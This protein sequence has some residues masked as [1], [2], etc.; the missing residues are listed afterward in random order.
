MRNRFNEDDEHDYSPNE[1]AELSIRHKDKYEQ[2][3]SSNLKE[4]DTIN[5]REQR[6]L[7]RAKDYLNQQRRNRREY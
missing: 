4:G 6:N 2:V 5:K 3:V 1:L 7:E